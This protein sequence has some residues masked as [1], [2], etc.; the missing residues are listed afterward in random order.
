MTTSDCDTA[1]MIRGSTDSAGERTSVSEGT[2]VSTGSITSR[3]GSFDF[4][5]LEFRQ[6]MSQLTVARRAGQFRISRGFLIEFLHIQVNRDE[7]N[8]DEVWICI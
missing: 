3:S 5:A 4:G 6:S 1:K 8:F 2:V 7:L